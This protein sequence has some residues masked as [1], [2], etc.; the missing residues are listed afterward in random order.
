M[1]GPSGRASGSGNL[2]ADTGMRARAC[3]RIRRGQL[4][5]FRATAHPESA[6]RPAPVGISET[7][8]EAGGSMIVCRWRT[9]KPAATELQEQRLARGDTTKSVKSDEVHEQWLGLGK[10]LHALHLA[11]SGER[12]F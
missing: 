3:W 11:S 5:V 10:P 9:R 2:P 6:E 1:Y 4:T 8:E 7:H 12:R